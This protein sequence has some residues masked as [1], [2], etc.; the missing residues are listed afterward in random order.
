[1][2]EAVEAAFDV[3]ASAGGLVAP[4]GSF[5]A[6]F[7][8]CELVDTLGE[9]GPDA[10][11]AGVGTEGAGGAALVHGDVVGPGARSSRP[12]LDHADAFD[13]GS[14]LGA[15]VAGSGADQEDRRATSSVA[16]EVDLAG[17]VSRT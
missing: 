16:G 15:V 4:A 5:T 17:L 10:G 1:M 13:D 2:L 9:S 8:A 14:G 3:A 12:R 7:P 11:P 6:S